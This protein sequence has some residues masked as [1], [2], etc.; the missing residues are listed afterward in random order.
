MAATTWGLDMSTNPR[1]TAAVQL[2]W[3]DDGAQITDVHH[4]LE[5]GDIPS[6]IEKHREETWAVDVPFG[7][8]DKFVDLMADRHDSPLRSA[9]VPPDDEWE[10]WRTRQVAQR[11]T[12]RFLTNDTYQRPAV[13][14]LVPTPG[15]DRGDVDAHRVQTADVESQGGPRGEQ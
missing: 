12:D 6:L 11:R 4:P 15:S 7:W 9:A 13:A 3:S 2:S 10:N 14:S 5:A 8:P 1:K